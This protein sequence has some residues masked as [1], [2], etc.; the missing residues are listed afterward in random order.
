MSFGA[1]PGI[2]TNGPGADSWRTNVPAAVS[3]PAGFQVFKGAIFR[4]NINVVAGSNYNYPQYS[5]ADQGVLPT[6]ASAGFV[7]GAY[8]G[9]GISNTNSV[10]QTSVINLRSQGLAPVR[11][12]A[13]NGGTAIT[14]GSLIG[15]SAA[16]GASTYDVPTIQTYTVGSAVGYVVG[17]QILT[18]LLN[19]QTSTGSQAVSVLSTN[20][21]TTSTA[22]TI[23]PGTNVQETVTPTAVTAS[24]RA[25][26][27]FTPTVVSAA[28]GTVITVTVNGVSATYTTVSGDTTATLTAAHVATAINASAIVNGTGAVIAPAVA[29]SG[30]VYFTSLLPGTGPNS[31]TLTATSSSTGNYTVAVSGATFANG[32]YGTFTAPFAFNHAAGAVVIGQNTT[33]GGSII[34]VPAATGGFNVD[35]VLCD[36]AIVGA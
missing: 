10:A 16:A 34:P 35:L 7:A 22:L 13:L 26:A 33:S 31:Y 12:G 25:N 15:F 24:V 5:A 21:I 18:S 8:A 29:I 2:I 32:T 14:V 30:V 27:T 9:N 3:V 1:S 28:A 11:C 23:D 36:I 20:G 17:Y 6:N 4:R 19:A